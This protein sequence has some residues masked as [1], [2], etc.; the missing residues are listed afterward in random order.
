MNEIE[1]IMDGV[2]STVTAYEACVAVGL[3]CQM[4]PETRARFDVTLGQILDEL[5]KLLALL[6]SFLTDSNQPTQG[7]NTLYMA[8]RALAIWKLHLTPPIRPDS[9]AALNAPCIR[10]G[11][12][13]AK[14]RRILTEVLTA[15]IG[16]WAVRCQHRLECWERKNRVDDAF[17]RRDN[18]DDA[19]EEARDIARDVK[20]HAQTAYEKSITGRI[21][22]F[23]Y[24]D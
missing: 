19:I 13:A 20:P 5:D 17:F 15:P 1:T 2:G 16:P 9:W 6:P 8:K 12:V 10:C 18:L 23:I 21:Y 4:P 3:D 22:N 11:A 7:R 24:E 14:D